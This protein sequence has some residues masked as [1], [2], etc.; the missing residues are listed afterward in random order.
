MF[1][2]DDDI[3]SYLISEKNGIILM[4]LIGKFLEKFGFC[5]DV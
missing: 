2:V 5:R 1:K 4:L 3:L